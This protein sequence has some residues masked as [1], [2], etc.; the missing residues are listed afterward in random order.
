MAGMPPWLKKQSQDPEEKK[1]P[2]HKGKSGSY[3]D[4]EKKEHGKVPTKKMEMAEHGGSKCKSCGKKGCDGDCAASKKG[5]VAK[6]T[7]KAR[8]AKMAKK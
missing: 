2:S 7:A 4:Q 1:E 8:I 6:E 3:M 5:N